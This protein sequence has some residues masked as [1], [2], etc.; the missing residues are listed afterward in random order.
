MNTFTVADILAE[1]VSRKDRDYCICYPDDGL[2]YVEFPDFNH[3]QTFLIQQQWRGEAHLRTNSGRVPY[4]GGGVAFDFKRM[5]KKGVKPVWYP[6]KDGDQSLA[7][8]QLLDDGVYA[9]DFEVQHYMQAGSYGNECEWLGPARLRFTLQNIKFI[10]FSGVP[11]KKPTAEELE[12]FREIF[13]KV[14][15]RDE[16]PERTGEKCA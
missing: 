5:V 15:I 7:R 2:L 8:Q 4:F 11:K 13:P 16:P 1:R 14:K 9:D 12:R 10:W 3:L 6:R